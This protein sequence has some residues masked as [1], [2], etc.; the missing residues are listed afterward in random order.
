MIAASPIWDVNEE[1]WVGDQPWSY[2]P[3]RICHRRREPASQITV[4]PARTSQGLW[5]AKN[6]LT[7]RA[8]AKRPILP[9]ALKRMWV[10]SEITEYSENRMSGQ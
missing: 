1:F 10:R 5:L 9:E 4:E 6:R 8:K 3:L 2:M 7:S